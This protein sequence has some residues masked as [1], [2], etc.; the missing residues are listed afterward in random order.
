MSKLHVR[1]DDTVIVISGTEKGK[2]GIMTT[3]ATGS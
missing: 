3:S 2:K 1:K